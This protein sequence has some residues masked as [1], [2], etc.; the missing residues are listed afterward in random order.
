M[1]ILRDSWPGDVARARSLALVATLLLIALGLAWE[2]WLAPTGRGTL[3]LKVIPLLLAVH[4]LA[5]NRLYTYRW[6]S[7]L[8]WLY[9]AE[10]AVRVTTD[11]GWRALPAGLEVALSIAVFA[12]C[13][14]YVRARL[15]HSKQAAA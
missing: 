14:L 2:L 11:G 9:A 8:I 10:G 5:T 13:G 1:K 4:G 12:G 3:A 15:R 7:L 6:M